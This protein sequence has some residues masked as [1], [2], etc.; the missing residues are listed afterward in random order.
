VLLN[1]KATPVSVPRDRIGVFLVDPRHDE[2]LRTGRARVED[3][4]VD[5]DGVVG[6]PAWYQA[7]HDLFELLLQRAAYS[8]VL[9][10]DAKE[11]LAA[12]VTAIDGR[13]RG[14]W[15][16]SSPIERRELV[17]KHLQKVADP[18][19][20]AAID[21]ALANPAAGEAGLWIETENALP[22]SAAQEE[23][24]EVDPQ[25]L[26]RRMDAYIADADRRWPRTESSSHDSRPLPEP[27]RSPKGKIP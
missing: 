20:R 10:M 2:A 27:S 21:S 6:P 26:A 7:R 11:S 9:D 5:P 3:A 8:R 25:E 16:T 4:F 23:S 13:K 22:E 15:D 1:V 14:R 19:L 17:R 24:E 18:R 12:L